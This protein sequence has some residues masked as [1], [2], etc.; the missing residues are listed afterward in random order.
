ML[1]A[2][3]I[4][5][6]LCILYRMHKR[7]CKITQILEYLELEQVLH[8][9]FDFDKFHFSISITSMD[10]PFKLFSDNDFAGRKLLQT[11]ELVSGLTLIWIMIA[12]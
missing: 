4:F 10:F 5:G 8:P 9:F 2:C 3:A 7:W 12:L 1:T 6:L 11:L